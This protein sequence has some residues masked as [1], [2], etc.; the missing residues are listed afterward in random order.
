[1]IERTGR[2]T[3]I[4]LPVLLLVAVL[5]VAAMAIVLPRLVG[6]YLLTPDFIEARI[7]APLEETIGRDV[8]IGAFELG[9]GGLRVSE[10]VIAEDP[11]IVSDGPFVAVER[12][13]LRL[14]WLALVFRRQ[15]S[16]AALIVDR[17]VVIL[18]RQRD[19]PF[20]VTAL[21]ERMTDGRGKT[22][23]GSWSV[24][25]ISIHNGSL[26]TRDSQGRSDTKVEDLG[27]EARGMLAPER[28]DLSIRVHTGRVRS[29]RL[30]M[31]SS[32]LKA[33][34]AGPAL[35]ISEGKLALAGGSAAF[36]AGLLSGQRQRMSASIKAT[37]IDLAAVT[38]MLSANPKVALEGTM[39]GTLDLASEGT[40]RTELLDNLSGHGQMLINAG[41]INGSKGLRTLAS[42]V[43]FDELTTLDL[44]KSGGEF[45]ID[46]RRVSSQRMLLGNDKARLIMK[47]SV[48]FDTSLDLQTWVGV[49]PGA[50]RSWLSVGSLLPYMR[51]KDGWTNIAVAIKG[52]LRQPK[53]AVPTRSL[54]ERML[55]LVPDAAELIIKEGSH[56]T[57]TILKEGVA[58]PG[59][60]LREGAEGIGSMLE[61]IERVLEGDD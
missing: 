61:G 34:I 26:E 38:A 35:S 22:P 40:A 44:N 43:G 56:A 1:M 36:E 6:R 41:R 24:A 19:G 27:L 55:Q 9:I 4:S 29:G 2:Q 57:G 12:L 33:R 15:V 31:S 20:G 46:G 51:D 18:R 39:A 50:E 58:L 52:K 60:I 21:V 11:G 16:G 42:A 30:T 8:S 5:V 59:A 7:I 49:G 47:G 13:E 37:D 54:A 3:G 17:P 48:G 23:G 10:L 45:K 32:E 28:R 53:V 25:R 14:D